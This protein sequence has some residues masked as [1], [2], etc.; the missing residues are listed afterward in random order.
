MTPAPW[1]LERAD[2][3]ARLVRR[4][5]LGWMVCTFVWILVILVALE[6]A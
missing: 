2:E 5:R 3:T 1:M 6:A 4:E